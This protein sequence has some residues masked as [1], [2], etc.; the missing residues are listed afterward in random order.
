[1]IETIYSSDNETGTTNR[2]QPIFKMPKNIRQVG[3]VSGNR[4]IYVEDYVMTFIKQLAGEDYS[5]CK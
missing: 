1:M 3:K 2:V 5:Q 4:K